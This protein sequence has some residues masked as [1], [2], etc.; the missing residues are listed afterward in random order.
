[1]RKGFSLV[2]LMI[3]VAVLGILAAMV[4]PDFQS[5]TQE[6]KATA[7]KSNLHILRTAVGLYAAQHNGTPPGYL[8]GWTS[9]PV[10]ADIFGGQLCNATK[11]DGNMALPGT[12]G[13]PFGPYMRALPSNPFN[14]LDTISIVADGQ[15]FPANATGAFGWMYQA[16]TQTLK[17]DWPG[18][19]KEGTRYYDY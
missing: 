14:K 7:A 9:G 16:G 3:V 5:H 12:A 1:M 8:P 15:E 17:L 4:L 13:F 11:A 10:A 2:E 19:D 6:S 18:T